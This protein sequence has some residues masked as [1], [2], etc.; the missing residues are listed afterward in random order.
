MFYLKYLWY[1][2][3]HKY[4]VLIECTKEGLYWRGI[5]HDLSKFRI[6]EFIPYAEYFYGNG[7]KKA[8]NIAW[9]KHFTRNDHHPEYWE[10]YDHE[11]ELLITDP[12]NEKSRLEMLCDWRAM[13]KT[14]GGTVL[15]YYKDRGR[16]KFLD[17]RTRKWLEEKIGY[18]GKFKVTIGERIEVK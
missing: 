8:F 18:D 2:L 6:D 9:K 3:K 14:K 16:N 4:Y 5:T 11:Y 10:K 1:I 15:E 13:S 7:T 17:I 12:M